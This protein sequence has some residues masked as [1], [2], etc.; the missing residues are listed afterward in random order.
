M[1]SA[2]FTSD[3][4]ALKLLDVLIASSQL[5]PD[6]QL[7]QKLHERYQLASQNAKLIPIESC[8]EK[9]LS[10]SNLTESEKQ[11]LRGSYQYVRAGEALPDVSYLTFLTILTPLFRMVRFLPFLNKCF[12]SL[13]LKLEPS[14]LIEKF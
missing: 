4:A 13:V 11:F 7:D 9:T 10:L 14:R 5:D 12:P 2:Q 3:L 1:A 6:E 8:L